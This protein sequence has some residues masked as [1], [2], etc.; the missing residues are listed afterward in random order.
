MMQTILIS[1]A[2][3]LHAGEER[4]LRAFLWTRPVNAVGAL[5]PF[6]PPDRPHVRA[7]IS[8]REYLLDRPIKIGMNDSEV[9][10]IL[11]RTIHGFDIA[12]GSGVY[13]VWDWPQHGI[14]I[15]FS[16]LAVDRIERPPTWHLYPFL[17]LP[18]SPV[19]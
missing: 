17:D 1:L 6:V 11:G 4:P 14:S 15:C 3:I 18:L 2:A 13:G 12:S 7:S 10:D 16:S 9:F 8:L 5:S 19:P